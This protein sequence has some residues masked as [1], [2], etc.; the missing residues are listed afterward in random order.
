MR[1]IAKKKENEVFTVTG[2]KEMN[3]VDGNKVEILFASK[4][5]KIEE[6]TKLM[7]QLTEQHELIEE[8]YETDMKDLQAILEA[9]ELAE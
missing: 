2:I 3:A 1:Y 8:Q 4:D 9:I 5:Y 7:T 6:I